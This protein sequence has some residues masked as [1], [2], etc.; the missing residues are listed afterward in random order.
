MQIGTK[1][2]FI[3]ERVMNMNK[4]ILVGNVSTDPE[5]KATQSGASLCTFNLADNNGDNTTFYRIAAWNKLSDI[6][7]KHVKK[8]MKLF[9]LGELKASVFESSKKSFL[10]LDVTA[11]K[12]EFFYQRK[13]ESFSGIHASDLPF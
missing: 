11:E 4:I 12:V 9:V 8:G 3:T 2:I 10:N 5:V 13:E 6:C 1:K 7:E